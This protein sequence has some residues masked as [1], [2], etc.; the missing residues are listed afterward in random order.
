[1][2][3]R[4]AR[5]GARGAVPGDVRGAANT[6]IVNVA[7]SSLTLRVALT[8]TVMAMHPRRRRAPPTGRCPP[9]HGHPARRQPMTP[10]QRNETP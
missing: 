6:T 3:R 5:G 7:L 4:G 2:G 1:M 10:A 8:G 9:R